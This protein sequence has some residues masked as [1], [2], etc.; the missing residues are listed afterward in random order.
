MPRLFPHVL[1]DKLGLFHGH[2]RPR[3]IK[4]LDMAHL[5]G[6]TNVEGK[7]TLGQKLAMQKPARFRDDLLA[8]NGVFAVRG[9]IPR[10]YKT[11][12]SLV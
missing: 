2:F 4:V 1:K 9:R 12:N 8:E 6:I 5:H 11:W 7:D 3:T 10:G